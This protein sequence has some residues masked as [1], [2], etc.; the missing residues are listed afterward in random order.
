[1]A[2]QTINIGTIA[3][4]G[5]GDDLRTA[6]D[7]ANSNFS[8]LDSRFPDAASGNNLG[9][10]APVFESA[11][12]SELSFRSI[13]A[14]DNIIVTY[15]GTTITVSAVDSLDHLITVTDSGTVVVERG[16]LMSITGDSGITTSA[17][18]QNISIE[19]TDGILSAD[20]TPTLSANL[21]ANFKNVINGGTISASQFEGPLSG[22]VYGVDVRQLSALH[23]QGFDFGDLNPSITNFMDW[24][25]FTIDVDLGSFTAPSDAEIDLGGF[26]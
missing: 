24:L 7:K 14:G 23:A 9:T 26:V 19:A 8:E 5:T 2:I 3:N 18:G 13:A 15:N 16:Q 10:G 25:E 20:G 17:S 4:D 12:D 1:M 21:N 11:I 22:L 6:F